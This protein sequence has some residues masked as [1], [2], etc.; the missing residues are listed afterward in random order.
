MWIQSTQFVGQHK[1][2][3]LLKICSDATH[4]G[5]ANACLFTVSN[6]FIAKKKPH[7]VC[8]DGD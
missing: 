8:S 6:H 4:T 2:M 7:S 5:I 1:Y 3:P